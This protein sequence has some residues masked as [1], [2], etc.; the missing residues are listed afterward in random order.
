[1][2]QHGCQLISEPSFGLPLQSRHGEHPR[3][4][5]SQSPL[6]A[7]GSGRRA[8]YDVRRVYGC[9]EVGWKSSEGGDVLCGTGISAAVMLTSPRQRASGPFGPA[10]Q[11]LAGPM[12]A[13]LAGHAGDRRRLRLGG[14]DLPQGAQWGSSAEPRVLS[15]RAAG[16]CGGVSFERVAAMIMQACRGSGL[17]EPCSS[18]C[19]D[20]NRKRRC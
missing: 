20:C 3:R 10:S 4:H 2:R 12:R 19:P 17:A 11:A 15:R 9:A 13:M 14:H 8:H 7:Y 16:G 1:M 5:D 6:G 18:R